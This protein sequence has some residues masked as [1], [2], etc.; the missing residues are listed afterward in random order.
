M[1]S[2]ILPTGVSVGLLGLL[3]SA[4]TPVFDWLGMIFYPLLAVLQVPEAMLTAKAMAAALAE[5]FFPTGMLG[6][7][8]ML[9]R[10]IFGVTSVSGVLFFAGSIPCILATEIPVKVPHLVLISDKLSER[11]RQGPPNLSDW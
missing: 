8:P 5:M 7:A 9:S 11:Q 1:T 4:Y 10:Y 3:L 2:V 6:D